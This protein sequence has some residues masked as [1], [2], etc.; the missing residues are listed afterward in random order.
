M[1]VESVRR[2]AR[3]RLPKGLFEFIDR[4]TEGEIAIGHARRAQESLKFCPRVLVDV[5][6]R[7]T[8]CRIFGRA[9]AMPV[10]IA[11]TGSAGLVWFRGELELARAAAAFGVPFTLA[12]RA[13]SSI[14]TVAAEA[15]GTLWF[16][17]Y[18]SSNRRRSLDLV[19]RAEQA[20]YQALVLTV[21]T[22]T[23]PRR[24]YNERN[25]FSVPFRMSSRAFFDL[26]RHPA[27]LV[28]V[29]GRYLVNGG[30][31]R[32]ENMPGRPRI[33]EGAPTSDMLDGAL[34]WDEVRELRERWP[35]Q[36]V[37]KGLLN[38]DDARKAVD[39][40][41]DAVVVSNHGGR[42]LDSAAAPIEVLPDIVDAVGRR[43]AVFVD[44][45]FERGGD[46]AK[47]LALGAS[48][49]L[50]GRATLWGTAVAG[51]TGAE[52]VLGILH[53]E[54]LY[55]MAMLGCPTVVNLGP[56]LLHG[57]SLAASRWQPA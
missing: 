2:A 49:V 29:L 43:A 44:G 55:T 18:A 7:S 19:Q 4:G 31:P 42:N 47:A 1:T 22:P 36:F 13:M 35:G 30:L 32:L 28:S 45:G 9:Q 46:I 26:A 15:G 40:G 53:R 39:L 24:D 38:P 12:T 25:G 21:D 52:H 3:R 5:S 14:E 6:K 48:A 23:V 51:R 10:A 57:P 17:L 11:P 50:V 41:A 8:A 54:L 20:G 16:Q 27:W 33:T 56:T 37:V 34:T